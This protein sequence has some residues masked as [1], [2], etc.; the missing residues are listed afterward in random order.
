[1]TFFRQ[2]FRSELGALL[3]WS[4]ALGLLAALLASL[5]AITGSGLGDQIQ[6]IVAD[7]PPQMR[8]FYGGFTAIGSIPGWVTGVVLSGLFPLALAI[9]TSLFAVG[10]ITADWDQGTLELLLA[11]PV[12]RWRLLAE[13]WL[14][15][16]V[17]L[18]LIHAVIWGAVLAG[19][20]TI[21]KSADPGRLA[22]A[23]TLGALAQAALGGTVLCLSLAFRDQPR[24]AL[25]GVVA[26]LTFVFLPVAVPPE[27]A[28]AFLRQMTPFTY[29]APGDL[30]FTGAIPWGDAALLAVWAAGSAGAA[31][32]VLACRDL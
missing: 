16:L 21:Q 2:H 18:A 10:I 22:A 32:V 6:K 11:L 19:L 9:W 26:A 15:F 25:V 31:A 8:E 23:L 29:S 27:S 30:L 7:L 1:M 14:A 28:V 3:A 4:A 17:H 13:R 24:A 12:R 5:Y 20:A